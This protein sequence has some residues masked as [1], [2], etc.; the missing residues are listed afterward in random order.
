MTDIIIT[1][2]NNCDYPL[3]REWIK[4]ARKKFGE[5]YVIFHDTHSSPNYA[6]FVRDALWNDRITFVTYGDIPS[7]EDWRSWGIRYALND[8]K[9]DRILFLEQDFF[10]YEGFWEKVDSYCA[11]PVIGILDGVRIHPCFLSMTRKAIDASCKNFGIV[12]N[13]SDHFGL[14]QKDI[15]AGLCGPYTFIPTYKENIPPLYHHMNGLSHNLRLMQE[16]QKVTYK[17]DEFRDYLRETLTV[18]VPLSPVY[19]ESV[20]KYLYG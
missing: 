1:W 2:P 3:W 19:E 4:H 20:K 8:S 12:P 6:L 9:A 7:G 17:P 18:L 14:I 10:M 15:E 5:V 13:V 11:Y 16:G